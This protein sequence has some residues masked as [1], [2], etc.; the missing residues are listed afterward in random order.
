VIDSYTVEVSKDGTGTGTV[1]SSPAGIDCGTDCQSIFHGGT[2]VT[3]TAT[4][5]LGS[6]FVT[7]S[8]PACGANPTCPI[9]VEADVSLTATF[10]P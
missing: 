10:G 7:W 6:T 2:T 1:Q 5:E 4:P 3:L 8:D 9:D